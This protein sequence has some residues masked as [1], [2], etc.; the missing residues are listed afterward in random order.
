VF[1]GREGETQDKVGSA[2]GVLEGSNCIRNEMN[3][4]KGY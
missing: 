3:C 4:H 1:G 2:R